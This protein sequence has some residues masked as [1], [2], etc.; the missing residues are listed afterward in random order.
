MRMSP[1]AP[2]DPYPCI[3][4]SSGC[5]CWRA[6]A[7]SRSR[8]CNASCTPGISDLMFT[9][10]MRF[11]ATPLHSVS[12]ARDRFSGFFVRRSPTLSLPLIPKLFAFSQGEF[13]FDSSILEIHTSR[14]QGQAFLLGLADEFPNFLLMHQ[15]LA[16][17]QWS[18]IKDVAMLIGSD[19]GV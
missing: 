15:E 1:P 2:V 7:I 16:G 9:V 18:M 6:K 3:T 19:V 11:S 5:F 13:N 4:F 12:S 10:L 14:N 8:R 17:A